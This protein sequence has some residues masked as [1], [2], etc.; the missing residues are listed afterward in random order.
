MLEEPKCS[1]RDC[2]WFLGVKQDDESEET[3]RVVCE[4]FP[5]GIPAEIAY[6]DNPH[7]K[8]YPGDNGIQFEAEPKDVA[9]QALVLARG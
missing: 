1:M 4:A 3:E 7:L 6:G 9:E 5:D 8:P 2:R